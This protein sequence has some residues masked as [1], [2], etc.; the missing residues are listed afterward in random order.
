PT[1]PGPAFTPLRQ[2]TLSRNALRGFPLFQTDLSLRRK[3]GLTERFGLLLRI[4]MFNIFNH[5]NFA[6]PNAVLFRSATVL[7]PTF[8][9]SQS[10]FG[11]GLFTGGASAGGFNPLYQIGGPRSMQLSVKVQF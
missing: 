9:I 4:D 5:P 2:G 10:M 6:S 7:N 11:S 3:I 1:G 8:G